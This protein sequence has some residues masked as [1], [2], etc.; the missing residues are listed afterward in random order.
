LRQ[1]EVQSLF[2]RDFDTL[3]PKLTFRAIRR[4]P[5]RIQGLYRMALR[6]AFGRSGA[7]LDLLCIPL[8]DGHPQEVQR[9]IERLHERG[10]EQVAQAGIEAVPTLVAPY[11]GD[12]SRALCREAGVAYFDLA[13]NAGIDLP[14]LFLDISGKTNR[15]VRKKVIQAP[16][17]GKAERVVRRLLLDTE[18]RWSMR[19]LAAA[20]DISLGMASM[21][22]SSLAD[23]GLVKKSR[24]GLEVSA[25]G[26]L[27][28]AWAE[29]YDLR[30]SIFRT[31]RSWEDVERLEERIGRMHDSL[32]DRY[33]LTLWSGARQLLGDNHETAYVSLYWT[34]PVDDLVQ[35]V[36]LNPD[37]GKTYVF[38]FR[39]Y[40]ESILWEA[41]ETPAQ[42]RIAHPLQ[43]Y[44]D[45]GSG[46]EEELALAQRVRERLL[47]W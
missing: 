35:R 2:L 33:A 34:G 18:R 13:G 46:D 44:L 7:E 31:Y 39:P 12:E 23:E 1:A 36:N 22:T 47:P 5:G 40:D 14:T 6:V 19:D 9:I 26:A 38:V 16:F 37:A 41:Q 27:L 4:F 42:L 30:R 3:Y 28:D 11:F 17:D 24:T 43:L 10:V 15:H 21:V 25:P 29:R 45:L 20:A 32:G 8:T